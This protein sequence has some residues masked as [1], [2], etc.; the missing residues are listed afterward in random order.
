M[1]EPTPTT[2]SMTEPTT[3]RLHCKLQGS[4][5]LFKVVR[6]DRNAS[7]FQLI[8]DI[9][10]RLRAPAGAEGT[11]ILLVGGQESISSA[12]GICASLFQ[13]ISPQ[14]PRLLN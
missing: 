9:A 7:F 1:A 14:Q 4:S 10:A 2:R 5:D 6:F 8:Q 3:G 13:E 12:M 11:L